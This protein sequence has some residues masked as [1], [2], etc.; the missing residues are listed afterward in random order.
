MS[1]QEQ[2]EKA[3]RHLAEMADDA[4]EMPYP[5]QDANALWVLW[6]YCRAE[7]LNEAAL[8]AESEMLEDPTDNADDMAYDNAVADCVCAI[9]A[10]AAKEPK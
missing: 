8:A 6:K 1:Q 4:H 3:L 10:L 2:F 9:R 7:T 5:S